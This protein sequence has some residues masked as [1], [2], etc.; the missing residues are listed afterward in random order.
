MSVQL[1]YL[2]EMSGG[3]KALALEMIEIFISQVQEFDVELNTLLQQK[4]YEKLGKLAHK[5]KSS[6][7]I[8][9]L[10]ELAKELKWLEINAKESKDVN[11]YPQVLDNFKNQTTEAI[12]ELNEVTQNID[13]YF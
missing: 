6:I 12:K 5:A 2:K 8:M 9:G 4:D 13:V 11:N 10:E 3:N 7:S 1:D